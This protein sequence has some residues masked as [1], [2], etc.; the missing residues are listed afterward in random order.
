MN[1]KGDFYAQFGVFKLGNAILKN[2]RAVLLGFLISVYCN[3][4]TVYCIQYS[5]QL[6]LR[7]PVALITD[8]YDLRIHQFINT[9]CQ[10]IQGV[11]NWLLAKFG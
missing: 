7:Y 11:G 5:I 8:R 9:S 6:S 1:G 4:L 10:V 2:P 3:Q